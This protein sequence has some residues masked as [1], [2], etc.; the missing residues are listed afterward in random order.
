M[1]AIAEEK[2][3]PATPI[4]ATNMKNVPYE[5]EVSCNAPPSP[6]IG[7]SKSAVEIKVQ[8][9]PPT[10]PACMYKKVCKLRRQVPVMMQ[11]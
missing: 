3:P 7:K 1:L 10:I 9:L 4:P 11:A 5:V 2:F 8:F 6:I